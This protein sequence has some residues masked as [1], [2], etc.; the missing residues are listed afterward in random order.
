MIFSPFRLLAAKIADLQQRITGPN[1]DNKNITLSPSQILLGGYSSA[2]VDL[3]H[4]EKLF[5]KFD[6]DPITLSPAASSSFLRNSAASESTKSMASSS[7][8][9]E[10]QSGISDV[11]SEYTMDTIGEITEKKTECNGEE[12]EALPPELQEMVQRAMSLDQ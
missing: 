10:K 4:D 7:E 9:E 12:L 5:H 3:E 11:S 1:N 6:H 2:Q 8:F